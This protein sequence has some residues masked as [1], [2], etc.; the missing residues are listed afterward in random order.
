M[1]WHADSSFHYRYEHERAMMAE[2]L[3]RRLDVVRRIE[4][5]VATI[6]RMPREWDRARMPK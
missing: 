2:L 3:G 4:S 1:A 5:R 6:D